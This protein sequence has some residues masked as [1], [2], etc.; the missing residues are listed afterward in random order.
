MTPLILGLDAGFAALGGVV[1]SGD[2]VLYAGTCRTERT[3]RRRGLRVADDDADRAQQLARF[4]W[5]VIQEWRPAGV[6]VEL[7]H[8]GAQGAR[9][10]RAM[11]MATGIVAAVLEVAALPTEWVTPQEVKRAATGRK[12]ASKAD[13]EAAVRERFAWPD[14]F[15]RRSAAVREHACDAAAAVLAAQHGVLARTLRAAGAHFG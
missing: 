10:N 3:S 12:D 15:W 2:H 8:G 9:A 1:I 7:P 4:L 11:G 6:V 5:A 13:V 14:D